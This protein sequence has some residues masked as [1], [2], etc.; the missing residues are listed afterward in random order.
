MERMER[1]QGRSGC[2]TMQVKLLKMGNP[3]S[4]KMLHLADEQVIL[5]YAKLAFPLLPFPFLF[6]FLSFFK[7]LQS[8]SILG[9]G[10]LVHQLPAHMAEYLLTC[11][12][13]PLLGWLLLSS[14]LPEG[15]SINDKDRGGWQ[16]RTITSVLPDRQTMHLLQK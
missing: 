11:L 6:R 15:K 3:F 4:R 16:A 13:L 12:L 1:T 2:Q 10:M 8:Y 14:C 7:S 5:P 9:Q